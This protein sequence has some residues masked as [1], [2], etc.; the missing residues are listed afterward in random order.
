MSFDRDLT[1]EE[2]KTLL[3][4]IHESLRVNS[5]F[6]LFIWL[7]GRLQLLMPHDILIAAW[8]DFSLGLIYFDISSSVPGLR[9]SDFSKQDLAPM[10]KKLFSFWSHNQRPLT[11]NNTNGLFQALELDHDV[12]CSPINDMR[13]VVIHGIKD[14]R[15]YNDSLYI[16]MNPTSEISPSC[17]IF[18]ALLPYIDCALRRVEHLPDQIA[19]TPTPNAAD[20]QEEIDSVLTPRENEIML[21][22]KEGKTNGEIASILDISAFTVKNHLQ[23]I[24]KK[25]NVLNRAQ[26]VSSPHIKVQSHD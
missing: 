25:L 19:E 12:I 13:S 14:T 3:E 2:R 7:Q 24:F 8:G 26:A 23:R 6:E 11:I 21:W 18:E 9:T 15:G 1:N 20:V 5:H 4:L 16:L 22:V 10:L 17:Y